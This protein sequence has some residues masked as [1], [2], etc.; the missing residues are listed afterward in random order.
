MKNVEG[1]NCVER[2][3]LEMLGDAASIHHP[4]DAGDLCALAGDGVRREVSKKAA[5]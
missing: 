1:G 5:A 2:R 3:L 4:I